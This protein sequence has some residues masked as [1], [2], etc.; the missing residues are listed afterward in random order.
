[1]DAA[2]DDA[3][4]ERARRGDDAAWALLVRRHGAYL[5]AVARP[6]VGDEHEAQDVV[7]ETFTAMLTQPFRGEAAL[8]TWLV[9][10]AVRQAALVRR[11]RRP[12]LR[13][14][15]GDEP[16]P[17]ARGHADP[18]PAA[19]DARHDLTAL[20]AHLSPEHREVIVL[21]ELEG[22]SYD[23]IAAALQLPRGTVESRLHRARAGLARRLKQEGG[24]P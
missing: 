22:M 11:R 15:R 17:D 23:Q 14:F 13:L 6:L 8:R 24:T 12:W 19:A 20:L 9:A 7:Q 10:I 18:G 3:V 2:P 5:Y 16:G 4:L 21:R 1:M